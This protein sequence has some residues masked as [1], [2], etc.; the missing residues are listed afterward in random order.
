MRHRLAIGGG[1]WPGLFLGR[2][3][4]RAAR[5]LRL[6][7]EDGNSLAVPIRSGFF[8]FRV[9]DRV[10][11]QVAPRAFLAYDAQGRLVARESLPSPL[12]FPSFFGGIQQ[13]PG[14]AELAHKRE[15]VVR[16][17][18]VG[19]A[20]IWA[21][22][23]F[24]A[25]ARCTWLQIRRA[26]WGGGCRRYEPPRRGLS[27]VV[28]LSVRAKGRIVNLLWGQVGGDVA[29]LDV[30]FQD[31]TEKRLQVTKGV[32]LYPVLGSHWVRGHRPAFLIARDTRGRTLRKRLL[33]EFTLAR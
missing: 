24:A 23:S 4:Q 31:A 10:L 5:T 7:L 8:L 14:G 15:V 29:K 26:V 16:E 25:P 11:A 18:P 6:R 17:T 3:P 30:R 9:P 32:F 19:P 22:P 1:Y 28:P 20:S 2:V 13:P 21:A 27:E 33:F 12:A